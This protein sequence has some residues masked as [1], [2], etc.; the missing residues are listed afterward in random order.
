MG[1][2]HDMTTIL[3]AVKILKDKPIQFIF[4]GGGAKRK[5]FIAEVNRLGLTNCKFLP[6]VDKEE[7][8]YSMTACDLSLVTIYEGF[9]SLVAPSKFYPAL[10]SGRPVAAIFPK[11]CYLRTL[12]S[13]A[14]CGETF[15]N[16]D[17]QPL[18]EFI[19]KLSENK[20]LTENMGSASRRY[21]ELFF[22]PEVIA[23]EYLIVLQKGFM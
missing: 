5:E 6:Y 4:I 22:T 20:Q 16:G 3:E 23:K 2:C 1:R 7:I 14:K 13:E 21:L 8:P 11:D 19:N 12:I 18:A 9:E 17:E 15:D 10:A